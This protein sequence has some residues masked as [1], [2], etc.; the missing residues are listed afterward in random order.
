MKLAIADMDE[1]GNG[2]AQIE[3]GVQFHCGLGVPKRRPGKQRQTQ[4][5]RGGIQRIDRLAQF[6]AERL[7]DVQAP[8]N[9]NQRLGEFEVDAPV[10]SLVGVGKGTATD[11]ATDAQV[12]KLRR[13][14]AQAG[15]DVA[16]ALPVGKLGEGHAQEL[17]ETIE[18]ADVEI[19]AI[20]RDQS[21]KGVPRCVLHD[22]REHE[23]ASVHR[24]LPGESGKTA[25]N[26]APSSSR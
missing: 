2:S 8:G 24:H 10:A 20:L 15:F 16:Q 6:H 3:Q 12:I 26:S 18:A 25:Q 13:L 4:I 7:V 14:C 17:I 1:G 21:A 9:A 22:L 23:L 11:I 19:A 5:D